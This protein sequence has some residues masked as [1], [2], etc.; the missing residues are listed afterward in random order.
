MVVE[1]R[2]EGTQGP[3]QQVLPIDLYRQKNGGFPYNK[4]VKVEHHIPFAELETHIAGPND[5]LRIWLGK[6]SSANANPV[7]VD[8]IRIHPADAQATSSNFDLAGRMTSTLDANNDPV[9]HEYDIWNNL[10]GA[11]DKQGRVFTA[12]SVKQYTE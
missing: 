7:Y 5:Y 10:M 9:F 8:D 1:S 6:G 4:W 12:S 11:K 3:V 2:K